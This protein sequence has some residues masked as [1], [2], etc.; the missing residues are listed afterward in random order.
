M[1]KTLETEMEVCKA[2][3]TVAGVALKCE[4]RPEGNMDLRQPRSFTLRK[5]ECFLDESIWHVSKRQRQ[6]VATQCRPHAVI[7]I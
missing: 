5:L 1:K 2:S 3:Q 4:G 7:A 6:V